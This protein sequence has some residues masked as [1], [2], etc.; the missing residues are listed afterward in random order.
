MRVGGLVILVVSVLAACSSSGPT[1]SPTPTQPGVSVLASAAPS[2]SLSSSGSTASPTVPPSPSPSLVTATPTPSATVASASAPPPEQL[3]TTDP[4]TGLKLTYI[5]VGEW[6]ATTRPNNH[7]LLTWRTPNTPDTTVRVEAITKC[8]APDDSTGIPC[9]TPASHITAADYI[10]IAKR[11][12]SDG[13]ARWTWPAFEDIGGA[14]TTDGTHD[15]YAIAV[16]L[17]TGSI[18]RVVV[19]AT[20]QTCSGC[21]Y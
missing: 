1:L 10:L 13:Y 7:Y 9:V 12:A 8:L 21:V 11:P 16:T 4:A 20:G 6:T 3:G 2:P 5:T 17:T 15:F 14:V 18:V 19:I